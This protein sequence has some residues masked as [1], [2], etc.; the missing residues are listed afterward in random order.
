MNARTLLLFVLAA[1]TAAAAAEPGVVAAVVYPDRAQ[2]TRARAVIC[3]GG[4]ATA[5]F[6]ALPPAA[7]PTSFRASATGGAVDGLRFE[8][9]TRAQAF[10]PERAALE[11]QI[12][13]L[14]G[15]LRALEDERAR[16]ERA[17]R[18]AAEYSAVAVSLIGREMAEP[19]PDVKAWNASLEAAAG[20]RLRASADLAAT[21]APVRQ[22]QRTLDE[23]RGRHARLLAGGTR[24]EYTVEVAVGCPGEARVELTYV[25]GGASWAPVYE[26]RLLDDGK[27]ELGTFGTVTQTTGEPWTNARLVLSTAIPRQNATPPEI[28]P[29]RVW[30]DER[31]PPKKV[32]VSRS[33]LQQHA[34]A[35]SD[36]AAGGAALAI[37]DQ[38][39]SVQMALPAR[40]DVAGDGSPARLLVARTTLPGQV[41]FRSAPK[42]MPF[43]FRVA[44]V[45]NAAP[46]PLLPGPVDAFRRGDFLGRYTLEH[47]PMGGRFLLTFG[48]EES[49]KVKRT[50]VEEA[51]REAGLLG[52]ARHHRYAYRLEVGNSLSRPEELEITEQVPVSELDDVKVVID[53]KTTA[54]FRHD[55]EDGLVV[56]RLKLNPG[57]KRA[58]DLAF[59]IE[60]P[61][62]YGQ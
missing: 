3:N 42:F 26:A 6:E 36:A 41:R 8:E 60:V 38:G 5:L 11:R 22:R 52:G 61:A 37:A 59:R 13:Q 31:K 24:T 39:L 9:R 46:F 49:I 35:P 30:A 33:E 50:V 14:E 20:A 47:V 48:V 21:D 19:R 34:Q 56:W 27:I 40:A 54:G 25:V 23:L 57:E 44:D 4:R 55:K 2:V 17:S 7:D 16:H 28:A 18:L 45:T 51:Q 29:L 1:P 15:E 62:S 53:P 43:F 12:R 32:L 10:G 58:V